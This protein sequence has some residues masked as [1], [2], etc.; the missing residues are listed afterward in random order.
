MDVST[1]LPHCIRSRAQT[2]KPSGRQAKE[3]LTRLTSL[4]LTCST[5]PPQSEAKTI[6]DWN[7]SGWTF[8]T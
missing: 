7:P 8:P 3:L 6:A 4:V 5:G 1:E 2:P